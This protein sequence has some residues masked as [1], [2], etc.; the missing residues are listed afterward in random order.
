M[1]TTIAA[2]AM[3]IS[4]IGCSSNPAAP[5][6]LIPAAQSAPS[7]PPPP[8][9]PS[10]QPDGGGLISGHYESTIPNPYCCRLDLKQDSS[11]V[12]GHYYLVMESD[13]PVTGTFDPLAGDPGTF[14]RL[15]LA[16]RGPFLE[17]HIEANVTTADGSTLVGRVGDCG[18][19]TC[20]TYR[21]DSPGYEV[22]F[23][24]TGPYRP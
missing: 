9:A 20:T 22:T 6:V 2:L 23:V 16:I 14:G 19:I 12:T 21:P 13:T 3:L 11:S 7:P 4:A 1:K 8:P 24:R 17:K 10:P 15:T 18:D 5:G